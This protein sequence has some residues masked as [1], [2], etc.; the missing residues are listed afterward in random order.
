MPRSEEAVKRAKTKYYLSHKDE[1]ITRTKERRA[2]HER[3]D[4]DAD[5][6]WRASHKDNESLL[7]RAIDY[8][9]R[10]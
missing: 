4:T 6:N 3:I 7:Q 10:V 1:V 9:R 8:L 2:T 5:K